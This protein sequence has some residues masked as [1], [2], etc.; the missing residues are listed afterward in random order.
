VVVMLTN[1]TLP[2]VKASAMMSPGT[3]VK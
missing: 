1:A 2:S 3:W